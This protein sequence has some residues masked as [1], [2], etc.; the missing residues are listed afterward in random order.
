MHRLEIIGIG[1]L[2]IRFQILVAVTSVIGK[3]LQINAPYVDSR[4]N[5]GHN[6]T[7]EA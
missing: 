2:E 5:S 7:M 1:V 3:K 6:A 4:H